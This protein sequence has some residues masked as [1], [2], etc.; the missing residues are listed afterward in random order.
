VLV[1][2]QSVLIAGLFVQGARR[3][4]AEHTV[5]EAYEQNRDVAGRSIK[6]QE[7]EP[8]RIA[9][10]LH[11]DLSQQLAAVLAGSNHATREL[12]KEYLA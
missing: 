10:D 7:D 3:R 12:R 4:R 5:R 9:R 6:A 2:L 1:A 11:D 8:T